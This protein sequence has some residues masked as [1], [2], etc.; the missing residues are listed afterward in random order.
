MERKQGLRNP[1]HSFLCTLMTVPCLRMMLKCGYCS[2]Q[3]YTRPEM[4][5]LGSNHPPA[6]RELCRHCGLGRARSQDPQVPE[7]SQEWEGV[8]RDKK[9]PHHA[10][11]LEWKFRKCLL[12]TGLVLHLWSKAY[13]LF[14]E[15][16]VYLC[17]SRCDHI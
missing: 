8:S 5:L 1:S 11:C 3:S 7:I 2:G 16:G 15:E 12:L 6:S 9:L 14:R 17:F 13:L 4:A 10:M